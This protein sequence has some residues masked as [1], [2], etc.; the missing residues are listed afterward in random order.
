MKTVVHVN[1]HVI[2]RNNNRAWEDKEPPLTAKTYK[3]N[4]YG[5]KVR[6]MDSQGNLAG[7]FIYSPEKPLSCGAKVWFETENEVEVVTK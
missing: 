3:S 1:Q 5:H 4:D 7:T 2:K 6:I